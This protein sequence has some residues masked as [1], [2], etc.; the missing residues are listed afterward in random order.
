MV[1]YLEIKLGEGSRLEIVCKLLAKKYHKGM[2]MDRL[3]DRYHAK[4]EE[5]YEDDSP[6][7]SFV[8]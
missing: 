4:E 6:A 3:L 7:I 2:R 8:V 5:N 1:K